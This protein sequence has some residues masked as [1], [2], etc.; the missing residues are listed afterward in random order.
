MRRPGTFR[1][2]FRRNG[3]ERVEQNRRKATAAATFRVFRFRERV[4]PPSLGRVESERGE[5][6]TLPRV[7]K[8]RKSTLLPLSEVG[9]EQGVR[10]YSSGGALI[11]NAVKRR[12]KTH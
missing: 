12:A 4:P 5:W 8:R 2:F 11:W 6:N 10:A 1:L 3:T 7:V 9:D